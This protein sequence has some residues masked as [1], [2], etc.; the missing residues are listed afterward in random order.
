MAKGQPVNKGLL[1]ALIAVAVIGVGYWFVQMRSSSKD[2]EVA[3][4]QAP[5][6]LKPVTPEEAASGPQPMNLR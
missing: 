2:P 1:V 4:P 6:D 3:V 5:P